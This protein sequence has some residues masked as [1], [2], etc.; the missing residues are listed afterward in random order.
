MIHL[1]KILINCF[2]FKAKFVKM[3]NSIIILILIFA[4]SQ[5]SVFAQDPGKEKLIFTLT[6]KNGF[7][8][9]NQELAFLD[10]KINSYYPADGFNKDGIV[11][12]SFYENGNETDQHVR[13]YSAAKGAV[14]MR[15]E[16]EIETTCLTD[17]N[18][19]SFSLIK[20]EGDYMPLGQ[21]FIIPG[22]SKQVIKVIYYTNASG[23]AEVKMI[24]TRKTPDKCTF[25]MI[26]IKVYQIEK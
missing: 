21:P 5:G 25:F 23:R 14:Q 13:L 9:S 22:A 19:F 26:S 8:K 6:P 20:E 15:A 1:S 7:F 24:A 12:F 3:K 16:F 11:S 10:G 18:F 4:A 17:S 2:Y